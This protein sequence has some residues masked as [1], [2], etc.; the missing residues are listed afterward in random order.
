MT[1][2]KDTKEPKLCPF[3]HVS[4]K[5][6]VVEATC[7]TTAYIS[8]GMGDCLEDK[9]QMFRYLDQDEYSELGYCGLAG[10]P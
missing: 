5:A 4:G 9:C 2:T 6:Y 3:H 10:K 7:G 1:D 8:N